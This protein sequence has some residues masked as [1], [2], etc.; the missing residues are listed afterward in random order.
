MVR[1]LGRQF[2]KQYSQLQIKNYWFVINA[3]HAKQRHRYRNM[4]LSKPLFDDEQYQ[5]Y[6]PLLPTMEPTSHEP[7]FNKPYK[8]QPL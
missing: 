7:K 5:N 1:D 2:G 4:H 8:I 6:S 3:K